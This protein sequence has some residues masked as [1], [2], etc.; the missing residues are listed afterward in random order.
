L[1]KPAQNVLSNSTE[2]MH[3]LKNEFTICTLTRDDHIP[4]LW[5]A[6]LNE[7]RQ[8]LI[9]DYQ[10]TTYEDT[11]VLQHIMFNTKPSMYQIL[12]GIN[13]DRLAHEIK[14]HEA[15]NTFVLWYQPQVD[16]K[17]EIIWRDGNHCETL[18]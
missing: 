17:H 13:K 1:V 8:K 14:R 10:L 18:R 5:F 16:I 6:Q 4:D 11:D 3:E 12:L 2:K 7:N 9:D 15:D